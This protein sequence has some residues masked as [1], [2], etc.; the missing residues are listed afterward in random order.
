[1]PEAGR[2]VATALA[3]PAFQVDDSYIVAACDDGLVI[4]D[5]HALHERLLYN[6]LGERLAR[7]RLAG[8]RMLLPQPVNVTARE[9]DLLH[10]HAGLLGRLGIEVAEF[11]PHAVAVQQFP[12]LLA[13]RGLNAG[14]FLR[15][16]LDRLGE[17]APA[18]A[19]RLLTDVLAMMACKAAVKAG[20][21]L[22]PAEMAELLARAEEVDKSAAC[23]HGRP[24]MLRL[25]LRDLQRQFRRT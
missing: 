24:T 23:P 16:L 4:I 8:Q 9:A 25:T 7:G 1:M 13:E 20:S 10:Q 21:P 3:R 12:A 14:E 15:D 11:G 5:Q 22:T 18:D 6:Q 17:G 19:E 2:A